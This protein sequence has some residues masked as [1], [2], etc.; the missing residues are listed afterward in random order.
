[1]SAFINKT[2]LCKRWDISHNTLEKWIHDGIIKPIKRGNTYFSLAAVE[3]V[4]SAGLDTEQL[5]PILVARMRKEVDRLQQENTELRNL[6]NQIGRTYSAA[7]PYLTG[8]SYEAK[9]AIGIDVI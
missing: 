5:K 3:A 7:L 1:M 2:E 4:E 6:I 9:Q 8:V